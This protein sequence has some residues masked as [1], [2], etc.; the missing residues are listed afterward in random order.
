VI[1]MDSW[2]RTLKAMYRREPIISFVATAGAVNM[3]IG[4]LSEHWSLLSVGLGTVGVA[5][6]L[7]W[8]QVRNQRPVEPPSR[9]PTYALPPG[10]TSSSLPMLTVPKKKPPT[11]R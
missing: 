1:F 7:R 4:G 10:S 2:T 3:A 11:N 5:I 9:P 8:W 6:A